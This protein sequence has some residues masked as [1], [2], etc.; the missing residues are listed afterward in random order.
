MI[1]IPQKRRRKWGKRKNKR[2]KK[3]LMQWSHYWKD[4]R[5]TSEEL[6]PLEIF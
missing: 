1:S 5:V 2:V 3:S 4:S 6:T